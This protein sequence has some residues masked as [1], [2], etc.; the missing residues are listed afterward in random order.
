MIGRVWS[1]PAM[2]VSMVGDSAKPPF[3]TMPATVGKVSEACAVSTPRRTSLRSPGITTMAPSV[4]RASTFSIDMAETTT[5]SASRLRSAW[6]PLTSV[7]STASSSSA[8]VGATRNASSGMAHTGTCGARAWSDAG[9]AAGIA[10]V[11]ASSC[12]GSARFTTTPSRAACA[13]T[14]S[15][16]ARSA[17]W[18]ISS[19]LRPP[20]SSA[21]RPVST[22]STGAPRFAAMRALKDSS[23]GL[24]T[25]V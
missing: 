15:G 1:S 13:V 25:S 20:V 4:R 21:R 17:I 10:A 5:P 2:S 14:S 7:P 8:T 9:T 6:S 19:G 23:V 24:P 22:R 11:M 3:S 12:S 18:R 16:T